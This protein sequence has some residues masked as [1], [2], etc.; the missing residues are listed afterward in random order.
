MTCVSFLLE[1]II[2][3][4]LACIQKPNQLYSDTYEFEL[5][6]YN[7]LKTNPERGFRLTV[8]IFMFMYKYFHK[9][10]WI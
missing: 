5:N 7:I 2:N 1:R 8:G 9:V 4:C 10:L 3:T 6:I